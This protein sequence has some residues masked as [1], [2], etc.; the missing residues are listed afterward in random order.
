MNIH[1]V[2]ALLGCSTSQVKRLRYRGNLPK[3][4]FIDSRR[5]PWWEVGRIREWAASRPPI[6]KYS[7]PVK[8]V[9]VDVDV[10]Q[11][12]K[13]P[14][15]PDCGFSADGPGLPV[16]LHWLQC[17]RYRPMPEREAVEPVRIR[18]SA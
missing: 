9:T 12:S 7:K 14:T 10:P 4:D 13:L 11:V 3:E 6:R 16:L 1:E 15:C 5:A 2:A 17:P 18:R 8:V